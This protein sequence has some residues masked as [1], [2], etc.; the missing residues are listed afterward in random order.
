MENLNDADI[1]RFL[2]SQQLDGHL[3]PLDITMYQSSIFCS[4]IWILRNVVNFVELNFVA[5]FEHGCK[6]FLMV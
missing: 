3:D 6:I 1:L 4:S 5:I 2:V